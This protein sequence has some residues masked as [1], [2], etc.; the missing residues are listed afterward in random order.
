MSLEE[1]IKIQQPLKGLIK[2]VNS[3]CQLNVN[4]HHIANLAANKLRL[5]DQNGAQCQRPIK[6]IG[7][8]NQAI[9][10]NSLSIFCVK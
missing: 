4:P 7:L 2:E 10:S 1:K 6:K 3:I 9:I 8:E 5:D